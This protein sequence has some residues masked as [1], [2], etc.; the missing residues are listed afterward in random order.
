MFEMTTLMDQLSSS[1]TTL[2]IS[3]FQGLPVADAE[4]FRRKLAERA[5]VV[6]AKHRQIRLAAARVDV[7]LGDLGGQTAL[8]FVTGDEPEVLRD[9]LAFTRT[10]PTVVVASGAVRGHH[11]PLSASELFERAAPPLE[12][13]EVVEAAEE[14][15]TFD[16][17]LVVTGGKKI[18]VI[19]AIRELAGLGLK[20]AKD[21]A[22]S[23][24]YVLLEG[25]SEE[26]AQA[27][28]ARLVAEGAEVAFQ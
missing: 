1:P 23:T 20:D 4:V 25:V 11:R 2:V 16:V 9:V 13:D 5:T 6:A 3:G 17:V 28:R 8:V 21:A 7:N 15:T 18:Q 19:K 14:Q 26:R 24:P 22:E 27:A 10:H 12:D